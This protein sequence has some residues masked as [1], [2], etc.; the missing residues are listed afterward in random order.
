MTHPIERIEKMSTD[1][2]RADP[3]FSVA[4]ADALKYL[5]TMIQTSHD[6]ARADAKENRDGLQRLENK[7]DKLI[8]VTEQ[9]NS[10]DSDWL[11]KAWERMDESSMDKLI[12]SL[13]NARKNR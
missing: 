3:E 6:Q 8:E 2:L 11:V 5:A 10:P 4:I 12:A 7:L 1:Q 13:E 9:R